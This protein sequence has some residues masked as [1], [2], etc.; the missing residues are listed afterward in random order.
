MYARDVVGIFYGCCCCCRFCC[1]AADDDDYGVL[2]LFHSAPDDFHISYYAL[3]PDSIYKMLIFS[4][5]SS[6]A[7]GKTSRSNKAPLS[8]S[9]S[10]ATTPTEKPTIPGQACS[11][12]YYGSLEVSALIPI[13][14]RVER[15]PISS[16]KTNP[17]PSS[18]PMTTNGDKNFSRNPRRTYGKAGE[19]SRN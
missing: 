14:Q 6:Q 13:Q 19:R 5:Y 11:A 8:S 15:N 7:S 18:M 16:K 17:D 1:C 12:E 3:P 4:L 2:L 10:L 9:S